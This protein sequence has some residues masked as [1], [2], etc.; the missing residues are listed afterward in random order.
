MMLLFLGLIV[1]RRD[2]VVQVPSRL[3]APT[4]LVGAKSVE[5]EDIKVGTGDTVK[6]DAKVSID[7]QGW[8]GGFDGTQF[9]DVKGPYIVPLGQGAI[10]SGLEEALV[11]MRV[12]GTRRIVVPPELG[13]GRTGYP[14]DGERA[15]T[16]IPPDTTL[17][18]QVRLRSIKLS[19]GAFGLNLF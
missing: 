4:S 19:Q 12:G 6:A 9:A 5:V 14:K 2:L 7:F 18:F 16:I 17:Y 10:I 15:G 1:P 3:I 8:V 11:G 13:Y